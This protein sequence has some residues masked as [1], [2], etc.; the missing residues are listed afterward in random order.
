MDVVVTREG[1]VPSTASVQPEAGQEVQV[2]VDLKRQLRM[3]EQ[4]MVSATR[5]DRRLQYEAMRIETVSAPSLQFDPARR[6]C[7]SKRSNNALPSRCSPVPVF[8]VAAIVRYVSFALSKRGHFGRPS[9]FGS[10]V[11]AN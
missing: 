1:F 8:G 7:D 5:T 6:R 3:E 11:A 2:M 10:P 4:V 9:R